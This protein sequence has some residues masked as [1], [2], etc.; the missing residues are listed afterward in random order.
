MFILIFVAI[1]L[2]N[3]KSLIMIRKILSGVGILI[4]FFTPTAMF[5]LGSCGENSPQPGVDY[6]ADESGEFK[7]RATVAIE[8][9][10]DKPTE[11]LAALKIADSK[12]RAEFIKFWNKPQLQENCSTGDKLDQG[13]ISEITGGDDTKISNTKQLYE[14]TCEI[15][16]NYSGIVNAATFGGDCQVG[17]IYFYSLIISPESI[18]AA[19]AGQS[20]MNKNNSSSQENDK[21]IKFN[22]YDKYKF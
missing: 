5:A 6:K 19:S 11:R 18:K 17:N 4:P 1:L 10:A 8:V 14:K 20:M 15:L 21:T 2:M 12:A 3:K 16:E 7:Y 13:I 9:A 22:T